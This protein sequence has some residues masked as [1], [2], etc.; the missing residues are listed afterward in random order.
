M[1]ASI[2]LSITLPYDSKARGNFSLAPWSRDVGQMVRFPGDL[3]RM[4]ENTMLLN[5][6]D[7]NPLSQFGR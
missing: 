7:Y 1:F 3:Y 6:D 5:T 2:P 4:M